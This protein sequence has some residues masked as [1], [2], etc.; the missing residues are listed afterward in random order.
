[1]TKSGN[2][3]P[4]EGRPQLPLMMPME[5]LGLIKFSLLDL[6]GYLSRPDAHMIDPQEVVARLQRMAQWACAL[7]MPQA[8]QQPGGQPPPPQQS[9]GAKQRLSS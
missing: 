2:D 4:T 8:P 5:L 3:N 7:P 1:M 6:N 9:P